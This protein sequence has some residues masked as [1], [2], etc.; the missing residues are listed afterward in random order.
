MEAKK[1]RSIILIVE[2]EKMNIDVLVALLEPYYRTIVARNGEQALRR[3]ENPPLPDLILLDVMMPDMDGYE[4]CRKI[5]NIESIH[6]I[7]VIFITV[8]KEE[9][10][11]A[12]GFQ[13]GAVDYI[14]KPFSPVTALARV[15]THIELKKRGDMLEQIAGLDGL[16]DIPNRRQFDRFLASEWKRS[17]RYGHNIS[18]ILAD[19][20]FFKYFNDY[21][22][23][24][25]GDEC[26]RKVAA[27]ISDAM[28]AEDLAAR[29][30]GEE[31]ACILPETGNE[32]ALTVS[33]R[34]LENVRILD[35]PHEKSTVADHVTISIGFATAV[36]PF[37]DRPL[38]VVVMADKALYEAKQKGR[39]RILNFNDLE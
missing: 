11:E 22:G 18:I 5:K 31:F 8:K 19:I 38:D 26:L 10:D 30:G 2:D 37:K 6:D 33:R 25:E 39:N 14:T 28:R 1:E 21:Y 15:K 12:K 9:Q 23:H 13:V 29:Y 20:D 35:V 24:A 27:A 7:P 3:L 17:L 36:P 32:G 16:T 34:I 4:V